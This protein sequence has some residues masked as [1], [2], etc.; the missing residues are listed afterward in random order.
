MNSQKYFFQEDAFGDMYEESFL[1]DEFPKRRPESPKIEN[2]AEAAEISAATARVR[3][4][5]EV[6][7]GQQTMQA[8]NSAYALGGNLGGG[9]S[10]NFSGQIFGG[11]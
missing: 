8:I 11:I 9:S 10:N 2:S 4:S 1:A 6:D 3:L 7:A 5:N